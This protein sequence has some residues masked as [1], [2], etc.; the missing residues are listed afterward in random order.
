M[1]GNAVIGALRVVLGTDTAALETGLKRASVKLGAFA[2]IGIAAGE[3]FG[4]AIGGA[5][6]D[7]AEAIPQ[8]IKQF[9]DLSKTSQKIGVP[10]EQLAALRH[11]ADLSDVSSESLTKGL[12]KL[13]RSVVDAAQGSTTAVAAYQALGLQFRNADGS[14]KSVG[15]L[16]PQIADKFAAMKDGSAKT[17]LAMQIFGKAG[18]D[19]IPLLNGGSAGLSEMTAE[20]KALGLVISTDTAK[21]AEAFNDNLTRLSRVMTGVVTQVTA[22]I[23]PALAQ[24]SQFLIDSAKSSGFLKTAT[25]ALTSAFNGFARAAIVL[26]DNIVPVAKLLAIWVGSGVIVSLGSAAIS[27]GLAFV[28]LATATRVLG[29]TMAAFDLIRGISMRGLLLIAGV[30][31]LATGAFDGFGEKIA[32]LGDKLKNLL[33]E[34][35]VSGAK[36]ILEGMGLNLK[37]L[38][39]DLNSW[40]NEAG[41]KG[42][43][44]DPNIYKTSKD[45]L[46]SF[47]ASKQ[48]QIAVFQAEAATIGQSAEAQAR[49]KM[50][51]EGLAI[52]TANHIPITESLRQ[53]ISEL[54]D[55]FSRWN[56]IATVGQ[57]VFEQT[58]T[59]AEQFAITM[60]RLN[61]A[62]DN[63]KTNS[64][65][66]ERG[67][68][69]AQQALVQA[70]PHAQNLGNAL[71]TAF[72]KAMAGGAKLKDVINSLISDLVRME[73]KTAFKTLLYGGQGG[74]GGGGLLGSL[75]SALPKFASGGSFDVGGSG[76]IDSQLVAF[77][78]S[79]SERV[80]VTKPGQSAGGLGGELT[81]HVSLDNDMLRAVVVDESGKQIA[82]AAPQIVNTTASKVMRDLPKARSVNPNLYA[83]G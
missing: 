58:R 18:A 68:A 51:A 41:K 34:G 8:T 54:A 65:L 75:F 15:D 3:A 1:A 37:G 70:N 9:D 83:P 55:S 36:A 22:N 31:A 72:D 12:G 82:R 62:F 49:A 80:S 10:V 35:A 32:A 2:G 42:G 23:L 19:L 13:A 29:L 60:E 20:A 57:Q 47:I 48:K 67:V 7:I 33:P 39:D 30:V 46:D 50:V 71:E 16:L 81:V 64:E 66:Y 76:G 4:R 38:T 56:A 53:K 52:A 11:A 27:V 25:N 17:A 26:Y 45:A 78:A 5:F 44:F 79:P 43:L 61:L 69:Q 24:F 21:T 73:A 77:K 14:L 59:P 28:K 74:V 40:K 63:G 6:R